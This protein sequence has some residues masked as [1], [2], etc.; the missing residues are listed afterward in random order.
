MF[1]F[2][3]I[4][5]PGYTYNTSVESCDPC[6]FG[7]YKDSPGPQ[8][9]VRCKEGLYTRIRGATTCEGVCVCVCVCACVRACVRVCVC[10]CMYIHSN[11]QP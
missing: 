10:C 11:V 8:K 5:P 1:I 7:T 2:I 9:C 3:G 4:C 6:D